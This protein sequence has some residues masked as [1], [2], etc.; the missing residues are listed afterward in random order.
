MIEVGLAG[1]PGLRAEIG[2]TL[3][4]EQASPRGGELTVTLTDTGRVHLAGA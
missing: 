1:G 4:A 2:A 3:S